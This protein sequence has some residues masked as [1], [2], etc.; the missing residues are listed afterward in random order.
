[1]TKNCEWCKCEFKAWSSAAKY[2][3]RHCA[4]MAQSKAT[5]LLKE[6]KAK[7]LGITVEEVSR[8]IHNCKLSLGVRNTF[9]AKRPKTYAEIRAYNEAHPLKLGWRR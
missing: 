8:L 6:A 9:R 2:C 1:M 7:E 4:R 3:S 5:F